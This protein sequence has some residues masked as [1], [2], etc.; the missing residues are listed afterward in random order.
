MAK[1]HPYSKEVDVWAF[2]CFAWELAEGEP[3]FFEPSDTRSCFIKII[4]D[5]VP[6]IN[7]KWSDT[8]A[9]FVGKCFIKD[10]Q[11]RWTINQL[12]SHEFMQTAE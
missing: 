2:G 11:E 12:L 5:E 10:P 6:R 1:H 7:A 9:D 8:F 3:P 4:Q